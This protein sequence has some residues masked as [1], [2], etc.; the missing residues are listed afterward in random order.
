MRVVLYNDTSLINSH[1]GP[2]LVMQAAREKLA[3]RGVRIIAS[4]HRDASP[5]DNRAVL[6]Q[7]DLVIVN[8]EGSIHHGKCRHLVEIAKDYRAALIN[9]VYEE[10]PPDD[11]LSKFRYIAARESKSARHLQACGAAQVE[12]VPDLMF[13]SRLLREWKRTPPIRDIGLTDNVVDR[14]SGQQPFMP[15]PADYIEWLAQHRRIVCGRYHAAVAC[16]VLGIPF[17]C[18]PSNTWK[19]E[20]MLEDMGLPYL[21]YP[22]QQ[23]AKEN[24]PRSLDSETRRKIDG[25]VSNARAKIDAMFDRLI[26]PHR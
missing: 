6:Q 22:T 10:N 1:F 24:C 26:K 15:A 17:T 4:M 16:C 14:E 5:A 21:C 20:G 8:G 12:V 23:A 18:W 3:E 19:I 13:G 25:Y 7:A 11:V 2:Q 9:C